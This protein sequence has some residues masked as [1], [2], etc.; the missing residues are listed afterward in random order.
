MSKKLIGVFG[1]SILGCVA[2][3]IIVMAASFVVAYLGRQGVL[4][5]DQ[6]VLWVLIPFA[7]VAMIGAVW[8]AVAWMRSI[9]EAAQEAHKAA[10]YWGGTAGLALGGVPIILATL[11][12]AESIDFPTLWGRTDPAAYAATGAFAILALMTVGYIVVWAW[13]WMRRR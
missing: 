3:A 2:V 6:A 8:I 4:D 11:P 5:A 9:D 7:F 10:W 13:W 1:W 12:H